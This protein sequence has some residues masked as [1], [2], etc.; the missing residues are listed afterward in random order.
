MFVKICPT[1]KKEFHA[2][3]RKDIFCSRPCFNKSK[4]ITDL[5]SGNPHWKGGVK[6][7]RGYRYVKNREHPH[8]DKNGYVAEHRLVMEQMLGRFLERHECIHHINEDR[9]DNRPENLILFSTNGQHAN[10]HRKLKKEKSQ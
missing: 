2:E 6:V 3:E 7:H 8:A 5:G 9:S 4:Q 1:C 10:Y